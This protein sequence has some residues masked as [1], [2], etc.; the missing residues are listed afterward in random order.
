MTTTSDTRK[1][2]GTATKALESGNVA[3]ARRALAYAGR[4]LGMSALLKGGV[5]LEL[6]LRLMDATVSMLED[7]NAEE[8][9]LFAR[10]AQ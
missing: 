10:N 8:R 9:A 2:I 3:T 6:A 4:R 7:R 5:E 1:A